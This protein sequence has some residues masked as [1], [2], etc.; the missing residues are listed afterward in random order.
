VL[1]LFHRYQHHL[2][3]PA[4]HPAV[5]GCRQARRPLAH[6]PERG[7]YTLGGCLLAQG[8]SN[9]NFTRSAH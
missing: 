7:N 1:S 2:Y 8:V 4:P 3:R 5:T 6:A 9:F